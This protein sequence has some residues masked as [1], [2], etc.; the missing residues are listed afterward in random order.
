MSVTVFYRGRHRH[1]SFGST[2]WQLTVSAVMLFCIAA[3]AGAAFSNLF[4]Q[5]NAELEKVRL[6]R[7]AETEE[8]ADIRRRAENQLAALTAKVATLQAQVNRLNMVGERL[9]DA[10]NLPTEEFNLHSAPAMGGPS[11]TSTE[12][13]LAELNAVLLQLN[14]LEQNLQSEQ[15]R[16]AMLESLDLNHQIGK[17][18]ALSGRPV[19]SGY[20]SSSFGVRSDP[21]SGEPAIHRGVDFAGKEGDAIMATAGGIVTWAGERFG[22]GLMVEIEHSDGYR[23]R[24]AHAKSVTVQ[25]G[26]VVSKGEQVAEMGNT[27]RSTGP[28]VHYEVLKNGQQIDPMLFVNR[29]IQ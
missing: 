29:R 13:S 25:I 21:F 18:V 14:E 23:T 7:A 19:L 16:F 27:G 4:Q 17:S 11:Q 28:H 9:I 3:G 20:L 6:S 10:A 1:F 12:I 26:Q 15:T 8:I 5:G 24:Y 2:P 22:Y